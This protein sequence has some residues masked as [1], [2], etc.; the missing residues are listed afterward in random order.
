MTN[1]EWKTALRW[2]AV[3]FQADVG[4]G[5][6]F[7]LGNSFVILDSSFVIAAK[8]L[9]PVFLVHGWGVIAVGQ[10]RGDLIHVLADDA[11]GLA[12]C[13]TGLRIALVGG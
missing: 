11:L 2:Q 5:G 4:N 3:R 7:G 1:D 10:R 9:L 8:R 6:A 12:G 13:V